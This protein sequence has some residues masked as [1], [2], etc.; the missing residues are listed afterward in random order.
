[1]CKE[2]WVVFFGNGGS[3]L[4][5]QIEIQNA[6]GRIFGIIKLEEIEFEGRKSDF[7]IHAFG[8]RSDKSGEMHMPLPLL[9][10]NR[11]IP[12]PT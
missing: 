9:Q 3:A 10:L 12:H 4:V 6:D 8:V 2:L 5:P 7:D 1:M 11:G